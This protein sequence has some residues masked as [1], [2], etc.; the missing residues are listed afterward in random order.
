MSETYF[1]IVQ[2]EGK[3]NIHIYTSIFISTAMVSSWMLKIFHDEPVEEKKT[4]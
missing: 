2:G 4:V 1:K 3:K